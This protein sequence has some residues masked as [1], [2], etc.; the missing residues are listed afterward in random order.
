[1]TDTEKLSKSLNDNSRLLFDGKEGRKQNKE[2]EDQ[3]D[4]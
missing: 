4:K 1:V 3:D 2:S